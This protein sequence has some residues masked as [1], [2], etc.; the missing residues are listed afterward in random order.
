[1]TSANKIVLF[2]RDG[3]VNIRP[4]GEYVTDFADFRFC[5]DFLRFFAYI[6]SRGYL[7]ILVSNQQCVGKGLATAEDVEGLHK[8]MQAEL[9]KRCA[10]NFDGIFWCGDLKS[11]NSPRRKPNPGMLL[12]ATEKFSAEKQKTFMIGDSMSDIEAGTRA[13]LR[14][15]LVG[16]TPITGNYKPDYIFPNLDSPAL[17][18]LF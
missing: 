14:T 2:D 18:K 15:I 8:N 12:E 10:T 1:M 6:K 13:G 7:A 4:V 3:V 16:N 11:A 9:A 5:E 17:L